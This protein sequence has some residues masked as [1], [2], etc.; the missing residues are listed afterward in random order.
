MSDATRANASLLLQAATVILLGLVLIQP[1]VANGPVQPQQAFAPTCTDT[2]ALVPKECQQLIVDK[3]NAVGRTL[4]EIRDGI[5]G[6]GDYLSDMRAL[7]SD[8]LDAI[9][10]VDQH[11]LDLSPF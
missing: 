11:L 8:V 3:L 1:G 6:L 10:D 7:D 5:S 4:V 2:A 9:Q